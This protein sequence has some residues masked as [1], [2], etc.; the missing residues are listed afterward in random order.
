MEYLETIIT[1]I[2]FTG[3]V[4]YQRYKIKS[5]KDQIKKQGKLLDY[6]KG[7]LESVQISSDIFKSQPEIYKEHLK[8]SEETIRMKSDKV[9]EK[10]KETTKNI[11]DIQ[12]QEHEKD[13]YFYRNQLI[14]A[15]KL[16]SRLLIYISPHNRKLALEKA[17]ASI[18]K[19][20]VTE[21]IDKLP[22]AG[23]TF[24]NVA[25]EMFSKL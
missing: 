12:I 3:L 8:L 10:H 4:V 18:I 22:Y 1:A 21:D 23:D 5:L 19:Q 7:L 13:V 15:V 2:V 14:A 17:P 24:K 16:S 11:L 9:I 20:V 25:A 6:Q